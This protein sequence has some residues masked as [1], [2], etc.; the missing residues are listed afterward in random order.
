M[1]IANRIDRHTDG[2]F[3]LESRALSY[4]KCFSNAYWIALQ[5]TPKGQLSFWSNF[6]QTGKNHLVCNNFCAAIFVLLFLY[7]KSRGQISR[8]TCAVVT[9][10][11]VSGKLVPSTLSFSLLCISH[12]KPPHSPPP[13]HSGLSGGLGGL[14]PQ[15]HPILIPQKAGNSLEVTVF[16][17]PTRE[18]SGAVT[19]QV[20]FLFCNN[21]I[22]SV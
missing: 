11:P 20:L 5:L 6:G 2:D 17:S 21:L 14:S 19:A 7:F 8:V 3:S 16:A 15:I 18:I 9:R 10:L 13:P 12:L 4:K 22:V 1:A